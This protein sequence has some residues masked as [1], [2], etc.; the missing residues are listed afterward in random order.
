MPQFPVFTATKW[1]PSLP[2]C[3]T[4]YL[5]GLH[6]P[7]S[8]GPLHVSN[9]ISHTAVFPGITI[10]GCVWKEIPMGEVQDL[11]CFKIKLHELKEQITF[12]Q[13][14]QCHLKI[15]GPLWYST[16]HPGTYICTQLWHG[17]TLS[18]RSNSLLRVGNVDDYFNKGLHRPSWWESLRAIWLSCTW[19]HP[20]PNQRP[21][22]HTLLRSVTSTC[23][24]SPIS[25]SYWGQ[26]WLRHSQRFRCFHPL[27]SPLRLTRGGWLE[28]EDTPAGFRLTLSVSVGASRSTPPSQRLFSNNFTY[29]FLPSS[30][31][32]SFF[33]PISLPFPSFFPA[34]SEIT[35]S[36]LVTWFWVV[37]WGFIYGGVF[38]LTQ[39]T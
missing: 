15:H 21:T 10:T 31:F 37:L 39:N 8:N 24:V 4:L 30:G 32:F 20:S 18:N 27:L 35:K 14:F 3:T 2:P 29:I 9:I 13:L 34:N 33:L 28:C 36:S 16:T 22:Q 5:W 12:F 19:H 23:V 11:D 7:G 1:L 38:L 6:I 17:H 25:L 26:I